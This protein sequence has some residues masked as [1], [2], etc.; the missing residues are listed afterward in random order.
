MS[1]SLGGLEKSAFSVGGEGG[2]VNGR[3]PAGVG[4]LLTIASAGDKIKKA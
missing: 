3:I 4:F 2:K 1:R